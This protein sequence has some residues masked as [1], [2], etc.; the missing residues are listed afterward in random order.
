M[1]PRLRDFLLDYAYPGN[2][3]ELRNLI[4]RLSCLAG[5][6]GRPGAPA[7]RHP[8]RG[9]DCGRTRREAAAEGNGAGRPRS[10]RPSAPRATRPSGC[11][12][13]AACRKSAAR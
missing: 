2:I 4:Y 12:S 1:T 3:R 11:S 7:R 8:A 9:A 5:R 10:A 13:S 6:D